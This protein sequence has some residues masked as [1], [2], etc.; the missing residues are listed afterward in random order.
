[1]SDSAMTHACGAL[2]AGHLGELTQVVS[3]DP[4]DEALACGGGLQRRTRRLPSRV[5][6][7][8]R[9]GP[10]SFRSTRVST[11]PSAASSRPTRSGS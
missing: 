3:F 10:Y 6:A 5:A 2:A 7:P 11:A 1:M 4:V 9:A 8:R